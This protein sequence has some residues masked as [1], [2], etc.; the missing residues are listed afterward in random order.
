MCRFSRHPREAEVR[1]DSDVVSVLASLEVNEGPA[2]KYEHYAGFS[3]SFLSYKLNMY[4]IFFRHKY[5]KHMNSSTKYIKYVTTES[6]SI[7]HMPH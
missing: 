2:T 7:C 4:N 6:T 5:I 1:E 3:D